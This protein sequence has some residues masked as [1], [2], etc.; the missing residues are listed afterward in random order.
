MAKQLL[1]MAKEQILLTV[2]D[3]YGMPAFKNPISNGFW[4]F[5][6]TQTD[7]AL[8]HFILTLIKVKDG[9]HAHTLSEMLQAF[10]F[11]PERRSVLLERTF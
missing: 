7:I 9:T 8:C 4:I 2:H 6:F 11:P 1:L 10:V 3:L 5:S